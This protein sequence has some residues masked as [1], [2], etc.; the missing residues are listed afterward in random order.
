MPP[1]L[2]SLVREAVADAVAVVLPIECAGCGAPDRD[3]CEECRRA[4]EPDGI[5]TRRLPSGLLVH[6]AHRYDGPVRR[7]L[8]A[9]KEQDRT[10]AARV[11][12]RALLPALAAAAGS[13]PAELV[14]IPSSRR[15]RRRRGYDPVRL[16]LARCGAR[17]SRLLRLRRSGGTQKSLDREARA[18]NVDEAMVA[19]GDLSGRRVVLVDDVITTGA[20]LAEAERALRAAGADVVGAAVLAA[21]PRRALSDDAQFSSRLR[22]GA[23]HLLSA[24]SRRS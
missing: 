12:A 5:L 15:A 2:L 8:L 18:R 7:V 24:P 1:D 22:A 11:L 13:G 16:L 23:G 21:T 19:V 10:D 3:V 14:A 20:T 6:A 17:P 4:I 9:L